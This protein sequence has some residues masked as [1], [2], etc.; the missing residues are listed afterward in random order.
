[1]KIYNVRSSCPKE[2][3]IICCLSF[4]MMQNIFRDL[5]GGH[6]GTGQ[7]QIL[8]ATVKIAHTLLARKTCSRFS[9]HVGSLDHSGSLISNDSNALWHQSQGCSDIAKKTW[10]PDIQK[11]IK[12]KTKQMFFSIKRL[13]VPKLHPHLAKLLHSV[14]WHLEHGKLIKRFGTRIGESCIFKG[15]SYLAGAATGATGATVSARQASAMTGSHCVNGWCILSPQLKQLTRYR[16]VLYQPHSTKCK[17]LGFFLNLPKQI[18][19]KSFPISYTL[20]QG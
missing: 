17:S 4:P 10:C 9:L 5:E 18:C 15:F 14:A 12:I 16:H 6:M 2:H 1:M 11:V 20:C 3:N 8:E 7:G 19:S 13:E